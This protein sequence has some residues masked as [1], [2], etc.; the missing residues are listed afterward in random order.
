VLAR[1]ALF[2]RLRRREDETEGDH[3]VRQNR[4]LAERREWEQEQHNTFFLGGHD[5]RTM[6]PPD[7]VN[8]AEIALGTWIASPDQIARSELEYTVRIS[9]T[10]RVLVFDVAS[11]KDLLLARISELIDQER[12]AAGIAP[13]TRRGAPTR[14]DKK[15][16]AM[17]RI[18]PT[19]VDHARREAG[20]QAGPPYPDFDWRPDPP[21]SEHRAVLRSIQEHHIVPL[22]DIQLAGL[23][24]HKLATAR[25]LYPELNNT[26]REI[27]QRSIPR[28]LLQKIERARELQDQVKWWVPRLRAVVG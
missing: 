26:A 9:T 3:R 16:A 1:Y 7:P 2:Q 28:M 14:A 18:W 6:W 17:R 5:V 23:A 12:E 15:I 11:D 25:V 10:G 21:Q 19:L 20:L 13:T 24:T 27:S 8:G 22:W 4:W